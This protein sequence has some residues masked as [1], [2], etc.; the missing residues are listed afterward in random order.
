M[1]CADL[2]EDS[3]L[4][5]DEKKLR[6]LT[7]QELILRS[8]E[9]AYAARRY[10]GQLKQ[11]QAFLKKKSN[12]LLLQ[13][14]FLQEA[15]LAFADKVITTHTDSS[16]RTLRAKSY[17]AAAAWGSTENHKYNQSTVALKIKSCGAGDLNVEL[18]DKLFKSKEDGNP[19]HLKGSNKDGKG[20]ITFRSHQDAEKAINIIETREE[21]QA[22]RNEPRT[23]EK[24]YTAIG[25][26]ASIGN[27]E[28]LKEEINFRN[29]FMNGTLVKVIQIHKCSEKDLGHVK[30]FFR[31]AAVR[32]EALR[33]NKIHT[34]YK[35]VETVPVDGG[36]TML[37][38]Q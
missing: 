6:E 35:L 2:L 15:K 4:R 14:Q 22:V 7:H 31:S 30:Q 16:Q 20:F 9:I 36:Q 5:L 27:M 29:S 37:Q 25:L 28:D 34:S 8:I 11:S 24:L 13:K 10:Q 17:A 21:C 38:M 19:I 26:Y 1:N 23:H 18:M 3:L 32:D 33:K 12:E